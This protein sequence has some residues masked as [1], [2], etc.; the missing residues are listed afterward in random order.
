[1]HNVQKF[2]K[3]N[4]LGERDAPG[5]LVGREADPVHHAVLCVLAT[6]R[7]QTVGTGLSLQRP[8]GGGGGLISTV[9]QHTC[10]A[11]GRPPAFL[12]RSSG[13]S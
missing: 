12:R 10:E 1:M 13:S 11:A 9:S 4:I 6:E 8:K 2:S 3:A 5:R 7:D